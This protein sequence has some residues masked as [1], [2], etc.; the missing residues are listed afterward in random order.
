M[1]FPRFAFNNVSRN[2]RAY[3]AYFLSSAF[4]VM[5]FFTYAVYIYHPQIKDT[6]M[7]DMTVTG[8]GIATYIVYI[9][10]IFFVL[11]SIS[12]FLKSRN[13]EFGI[14][15]ILGAR[16]GQI[17]RLIFLENMIIG[18]ASILTGI[19]SGLLLTKLFL[20]ISARVIDMEELPF[21][22]PG[23]A[24]LLTIL[25]F[26]TLFVVVS[27]FTLLFINKTKVLELLKGTSKPKKEP[28]ASFLLA[29]FGTALLVTGYWSLHRGLLTPPKL[30][31]AAVT[32]IAGTYFFYSQL[33]VWIIRFVQRR[34]NLTWG[35]VRLLWVSEMSYKLKDNARILFMVTVMI[36]LA[37][38]S[39]GFVLALNET[40]KSTYLDNPADLTY[41]VSEE[42]YPEEEIAHIE[43][44]L[45]EEGLEYKRAWF[46]TLYTEIGNNE[47]GYMRS[48]S[49]TRYN[50]LATTLE[51]PTISSLGAEEVVVVSTEK[52]SRLS[53]ELEGD[54]VDIIQEKDSY[55][56]RYTERTSGLPALL[57]STD[58]RLL[59]LHDDIYAS[60]KKEWVE[61]G[62][63]MNTM[64]VYWYPDKN[65]IPN[66][67]SPEVR[68]G[69]ALWEWNLENLKSEEGGYYLSAKAQNYMEMKQTLGLFSFIGVFIALI[70]S[71][72]SASFL[73][74]K[75]HTELSTDAK[76]YQALSKIGLSVQEMGRSAT[77]Q[78]ALLFFIPIIVATVQS[79]VVLEPVLSYS[80]I[81]TFRGPV[82][83]TAG[84][85]LT[86]QLVYFFIVRARY[87]R[88]VK[89]MMV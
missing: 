68:A 70:F 13:R 22:W 29:L 19:L 69:V 41:Y 60:L 65:G 53:E 39:A 8:M 87:I 47:H 62:N 24:I 31:L 30:L 17:N 7:G 64:L 57:D 33:S 42:E 20:L 15:T 10:A 14:L 27:A 54:T 43:S 61:D 16:S 50:E 28:K 4:M 72:S 79:L 6:P 88:A 34:R 52:A 23:E 5:I 38:M 26:T 44:V 67:E 59:V 37:S 85:F 89:Q 51:E 76:S 9:F 81:P 56:L 12:V 18:A 48:I 75:L 86:L 84:A 58:G 80:G 2:S 66:P 11:Y 35:G 73:Y 55:F 77:I 45:E 25:S 32:G 83:M 36:A 40:M 49:L 82:M 71:M 1:N 3:I 21:Y 78:I 63:L 74:F 46:E